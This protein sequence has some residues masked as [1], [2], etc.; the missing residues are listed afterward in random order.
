MTLLLHYNDIHISNICIY[1][2][3]KTIHTHFYKLIY[4]NKNIYLNNIDILIP[5]KQNEEEYNKFI[6]KIKA[7][8]KEI[9]QK[10]SFDKQKK[11]KFNSHFLQ[12]LTENILQHFYS[13][14]VIDEN[15]NKDYDDENYNKAIHLTIKDQN[16]DFQL[17]DEKNE[18]EIVQ[19]QKNNIQHENKKLY[20]VLR[21]IGIIETNTNINVSFKLHI[22]NNYI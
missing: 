17:N 3:N 13:S 16:K 12:T 21:I 1:Y 9:L 19:I 5:D 8:E 4:S 2:S 14:E 22:F 11:L 18:D 10:Y 15:E 7:L 6:Q 20:Y